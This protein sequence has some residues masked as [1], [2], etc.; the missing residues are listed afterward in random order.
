MQINM[1]VYI[2]VLL[3]NL[4]III[5]KEEKIRSSNIVTIPVFLGIVIDFAMLNFL[6]SFDSFKKLRRITLFYNFS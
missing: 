4:K 6:I 2:K 1:S 3:I 5:R